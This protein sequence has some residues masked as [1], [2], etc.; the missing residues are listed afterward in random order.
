MLDFL[1]TT[2]LAKLLVSRA[3][4]MRTI[5]HL[6]CE[7]QQ[8]PPPHMKYRRVTRGSVCLFRD[9]FHFLA[10]ILSIDVCVYTEWELL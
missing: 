8:E 2:V 4:K 5:I 1:E 10:N 9:H 6:H 3:R 7:T